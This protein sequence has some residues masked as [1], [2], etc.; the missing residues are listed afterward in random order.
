MESLR[1]YLKEHRL[2][3]DGAMG[4]YYAELAKDQTSLVERCTL[5]NPDIIEK[6][7]NEYIEAGA[8]LIRTNTC[9]AQTKKSRKS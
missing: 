1:E 4:T 3:T 7:H 9:S 5:E 6:I 8:K 2:I